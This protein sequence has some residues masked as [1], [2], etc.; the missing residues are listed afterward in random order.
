[1]LLLADVSNFGFLS[2]VVELVT[3]VL[4]LRKRIE[5]E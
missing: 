4:S 5:V 1:M 2:S 3:L